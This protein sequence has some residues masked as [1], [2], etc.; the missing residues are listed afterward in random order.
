MPK[1]HSPLFGR[2]LYVNLSTGESRTLDT[3]AHAAD[4]VGGRGLAA[5]LAWD[6]LPPGI[7]ALDEA[8]HL[9][10]TP[11]ALVGTPAPSAGRTT[12][13]G[14]SPQAYPH[15]WYTRSSLGGHWGA[16][17]R[18]AGYDG[19][20]VTGRA[21]EPVYLHV[22]DERVTVR[23]AEHLWGL[24]LV[25]TQ[26]R[27]AEELPEGTRVLAIGPAGE[28]RCRYAI[29]ATGTESAAGQGGFGA[30]MGA[31]NLKA[32][33][34]RGTG[35]VPV[36]HPREALR[37]SREVVAG[38]I[39]IYGRGGASADP[40]DDHSGSR[41]AP[42]T[43]GCPRSCGGFYADVPGA[44]HTER[45]YTGHLH[46]CSPIFT[47]PNGWL[48]TGYTFRAG[49]EIAQ[50]C[51]D[52]GI[53][54]WEIVFGLVPWILRLQARGEMPPLGDL[55][56]D[57]QDPACL[58]TII[59]AI[60]YR[61]G[62]GDLLAEGLPRAVR[63]LGV[64]EDV[65]GELYPGYG[66]ASHWDGHGAFPTP[67]YPYWLV[68]ALQWAF[69]SR[70]PLGGGHGY[71]TN[72]FRLASRLEPQAGDPATRRRLLEVGRRIYGSPDAVDPLSGYAGKALAGAYH[73]DRNALKDCL[74]I[75]DN[76][77]PMLADSSA[78]DFL[79]AVG[80]IPGPYLEHYVYEPLCEEPLDRD[81]FYRVGT[82][83]FTLERLLAVRNWG[84]SRREDEGIMPYLAHPER[85]TSPYLGHPVEL[86]AGRFRGLLDECYALRGW[87]RATG[88][89]SAAALERLGL[90]D[91]G[92]E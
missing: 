47:S 8:N 56:L 6:L 23:S 83:V 42:C 92:G 9:F 32:I 22:E 81:A 64:G 35:A 30:V 25:E 11:G 79:C 68:T 73:Q 46:C 10:F 55:S 28:N 90:T 66:Q 74:G 85:S 77:F 4:Y 3:A 43:H 82:R 50:V 52:L 7:G 76:I 21:A 36:A 78:P 45:T 49:F 40:T 15:E 1:A 86:D 91:L 14:L 51:N 17:L 84:R 57:L 59:E 39:D 2:T 67:Y 19:L 5:R 80:G 70:D 60:A 71:T 13:C 27:L 24:G 16:A 41:R 89:P 53:N 62:A 33:A 75:C 38:I 87:D 29:V 12:I 61:R 72:I 18:Y 44:V 37:R 88:L 69:D 34:V 26:H 54:H 58:L 20:V 48:G 65:V 63:T 31:K